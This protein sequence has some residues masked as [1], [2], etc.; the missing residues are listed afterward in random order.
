ML[1]YLALAAMAAVVRE[2]SFERAASILGVTP[3][4]VSQ[5]VKGLEERLGAMLITRGTPCL[6]TPIGAKLCA[7]LEQVRLL[8]ADISDDLH[9][10]AGPRGERPTLRVA[11]NSDSLSTWFPEAA[12][13][14][15]AAT[16]ALLDLVLDDEAHTAERLRTGEVVAAV[17]ADLVAVAGCKIHP[18]GALDY[19]A[20]TSPAFHADHFA[21]GVDGRSLEAAPMLRFDRWRRSPWPRHCSRRDGWSNYRRPIG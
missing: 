14:F 13:Q 20:V 1:D 8:E 3:S 6:P 18:L 10:L 2:G 16:G 15:T 11:V 21:D 4:A 12:A 5:R 17:S 19:V 7:H 9:G